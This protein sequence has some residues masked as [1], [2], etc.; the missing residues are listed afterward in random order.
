[1]LDAF[2][3][4]IKGLPMSLLLTVASFVIGGIVA[5]PLALGLRSKIAPL[6]WVLRFL[7]DLIRGVPIIVWIFVAYYGISEAMEGS[8]YEIENWVSAILSLSIVSTAYL[9]EIYRGGI[10]SVPVGQTEAA[11]ALGIK[12]T[13]SFLKIVAPQ[14]FK[15]SMPSIAT[16]GIGLFKDTSIASVI[17]VEDMVFQARSFAAQNPDIPGIY[18]YAIAAAIYVIVSVP[19]AMWSRRVD[20]KLQA[21]GH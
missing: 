15:I 14:A 18:P 11:H 20:R 3:A 17:I 10:L 6:R 21:G 13:P 2:L 19:V 16:Y 1:M 4:V 8:G 12:A 9:A 5:I 7:V